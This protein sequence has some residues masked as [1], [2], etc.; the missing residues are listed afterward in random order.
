M[1]KNIFAALREGLP[2][3]DIDSEGR[4][5]YVLIQLQYKNEQA[6]FVRGY[7]RH[8]FHADHFEEFY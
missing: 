4:F 6:L 5:K 3:V 8:E 2:E 7:K 1:D